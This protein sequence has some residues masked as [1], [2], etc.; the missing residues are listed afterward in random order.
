MKGAVFFDRDGVLNEVRL[1]DGSGIAPWHM[2]QFK[3]LPDARKAVQTI[4]DAGYLAI[5][6]TNQP[7]ITTGEL[8]P[9]ELERIHAALKQQVPVHAIYCCP[10]HKS[11]GCLCHKP[12]PGLLEQAQREWKID[13]SKSFLI[14]DRW[15]D[16][17]AGNAVGCSSIL[18]E[19]AYSGD[20]TGAYAPAHRVGTLMEAVAWVLHRRRESL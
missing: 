18:L 9:E 12:K 5:V 14:G 15:R 19:R 6:V 7:E 1:I 4:V 20:C 17:G 11:D 2:D 3:I 16:I 10:H 13:F 8:L